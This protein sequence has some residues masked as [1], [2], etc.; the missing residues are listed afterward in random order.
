MQNES[1]ICPVL[2]GG[3]LLPPIQGLENFHQNT[4]ADANK[5]QNSA[6]TQ[7]VD[8]FGEYDSCRRHQK[9]GVDLRPLGATCLAN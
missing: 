9:Q 7:Q 6:L 3:F 2:Q 5:E 8:T 4:E 1:R